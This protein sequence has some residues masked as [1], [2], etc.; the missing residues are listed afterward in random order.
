MMTQFIPYMDSS[1]TSIASTMCTSNTTNGNNNTTDSHRRQSPQPVAMWKTYLYHLQ[2][3]APHPKPIQ[4]KH[5]VP[6]RPKQ[7]GLEFHGLINRQDVETL[8]ADIRESQ[9]PPNSYTLAIRF[10]LE[11]K[12]YKLY[13]DNSS[14]LHY[15]GEKRFD[16][17]EDLV[18]DGLISFYLESKASDYIALMACDSNCYQ[19]SPYAQYKTQLLSRHQRQQQTFHQIENKDSS[20]NSALRQSVRSHDLNYLTATPPSQ[21]H[22]IP[23]QRHSTTE[24]L[25]STK[26]SS[27]SRSHPPAHL[28]QHSPAM[29]S[30]LTASIG[31]T[32]SSNN[33]TS[34]SIF[35]QTNPLFF[36]R[37]LIM[38]SEKQHNFKLHS[39]K[40]PH[41]CDYCANFMWGLVSQ[42]VKC[43][44]CGF[45]AHK[46]CSE[47]VP[48]DCVPQMKYI[49]SIFGVDLTTLIKAGSGSS[50]NSIIPIVV[51]KCI[52]EIETR[53][54]GLDTDG[55]YR[56]PGF[57][58]VVE[59]IKYQFEKDS[60]AIDLSYQRYPDIHAIACVLKLY[61]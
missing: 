42:G 59:E 60:D 6:N 52:Y 4:C 28:Q 14:S 36:D 35:Q 46:R 51:D 38:Q 10:N 44:D 45:E 56:I 30:S 53:S 40:G 39:F 2:Q 41:W 21:S 57:S 32:I 34:S 24:L 50:S 5:P 33:K 58:D 47:K 18:H 17:I 48:Q 9:N 54:N 19:E 55:L 31:Q 27:F 43:L 1:T 16:L 61:L 37:I 13:Y 8:M 11:I 15:V 25:T 26:S 20:L 49:K 22:H 23:N 3:Q 7:Y 29:T 12:Y